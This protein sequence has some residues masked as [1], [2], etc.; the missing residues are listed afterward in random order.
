M[1]HIIIYHHDS[2]IYIS[3]GVTEN[4]PNALFVY[5]KFPPSYWGFKYALDFL[6]KKS[7]MP[8]PGIINNCRHVSKEL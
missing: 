3:L 5:P 2:H 6:G 1:I 8:P 4:M 7:S